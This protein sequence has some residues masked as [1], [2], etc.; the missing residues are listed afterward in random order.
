MEQKTI[1]AIVL[2]VLVLISAV[3]AFQMTSLKSKVADGGVSVQK[4][5]AGS[6]PA[7]A[8]NSGRTQALPDN[9]KNLP[10]MVGGC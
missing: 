3:Q 10:T 8:A 5:G 2:G 4:G 6:A 9:I 1:F 7:P